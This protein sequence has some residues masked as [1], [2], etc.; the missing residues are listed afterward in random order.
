MS[1]PRWTKEQQEVIDSR[2]GNLLVAAAA[3]SGKTAVLVQRIINMITDTTNP[4]DID[5]LLVVTFTNAAASEMKERVQ[6][7]IETLLEKD[8]TNLQLK[9]QLVLL[10][11][12]NITTIHSFCLNII[13]EYFYK[14]NLTSDFR[15]GS[16]QELTLLKL[17][18]MDEVFEEL[19]K[20]ENEE[21]YTLVDQFGSTRGDSNLRELLLNMYH[22]VVSSPNPKK[23]LQDSAKDFY[24]D[25][26]F[27]FLQTPA[28]KILIETLKIEFEGILQS[29]EQIIEQVNG[30]AE[31][32]QYSTKYLSE[33][34]QFKK[35]FDVFDKN[36]NGIKCALDN[37]VFEDY[38]SGMKRLPKTTE[39]HIKKLQK[40]S[41]KTRDKC[42]D[43]IV[44][45]RTEIFFREEDDIKIEY[46]KLYTIS[47]AISDILSRF[48][49]KY[50]EVKKINNIIDFNDIEHF[51]IKLLTDEVNGDLVPSEIA[52]IYS[53][54]FE[55]IFIDEYQDSNLTQELILTSISR[56][57]E[58]RFMVGDLKQSIYKFRQARPEIF[59]EKYNR[60]STNLK[61]IDKKILLHKNF[62]SRGEVLDATNFIFEHIMRSEVGGLEYGEEEKLNLGG[63]FKN[64]T[65]D[66]VITGGPAELHIISNTKSSSNIES[67]DISDEK[68]ELDK[69]QQEA[70]VIGNIIKDLMTPNNKGEIFKVI[71]KKTGQYRKVNFGDIVILLR[72]TS[73]WQDTIATELGKSGIPVTMSSNS[74]YLNSF[75]IK[76]SMAIMKAISNPYEDIS[77][78]GALRTS[79]FNF[80]EDD[81]TL[82]KNNGGNLCFYELLEKHCEKDNELGMK[83]KITLEKINEFIDFSKKHSIYETLNFIYSST[84][85]YTFISTLPN[86]EI[87]RNNL[88]LLLERA[89]VFSKDNNSSIDRFIKYIED[90]IDNELDLEGHSSITGGNDSVNIM[91]IHKSKGLEFPVVICAGMGKQFN[92][93]DL[94]NPF[95]YHIDLGYGP[96]IIDTKR[97]ITYHSAKKEALKR[98]MHIETLAE[99]IRILYVAL[100]RPKEKLIITGMVND[101]ESSMEKWGSFTHV[102]NKL[103]AYA[104]LKSSTYLD[105]I[106]PTVLKHNDFKD[107]CLEYEIEDVIRTKHNSKWSYKIWDTSELSDFTLEVDDIQSNIKKDINKEFDVILSNLNKENSFNTNYKKTIK[108]FSITDFLEITHSKENVNDNILLPDLIEENS[109]F[110][111]TDIGNIFHETMQ[112]IDIRNINS[113]K[114]VYSEIDRLVK[115][116]LLLDVEADVLNKSR[117]WNFINSDLGKRIKNSKDFK[118]EQ[119]ISIYLDND[120][121]MKQISNIDSAIINGIIDIYFEE[122][123]GLVIIDYKTDYVDDKNINNII[124]EYSI[125]LKLY[126]EA[127]EKI[128]NKKVKECYLHLFSKQ[129]SFKI[130]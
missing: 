88:E 32:K 108:S 82:L 65:E 122:E 13:K 89:N 70:K 105:W 130:I 10:E 66:K 63:S 114:D 56:N 52:S 69:I 72:S 76:T 85:Y 74:G 125:Q 61:E 94:K 45:L 103:P 126:K 33:F 6:F 51:A 77:L 17:K 127:L 113:K 47:K 91:T 62:R 115:N 110:S 24:I 15:I 96:Q 87:R 12:A 53:E 99:E 67:I 112:K 128:T 14:L 106:V 71:D 117:I 16:E 129:E 48:I 121:T 8:A 97:K 37:I 22:F 36:W 20:E 29:M 43:D 30:I 95:L 84:N 49:D 116:G 102:E 4:I 7:A 111:A 59:L 64:N 23:W 93:M 83:C 101:L 55:E 3:G 39:E 5:K 2:K 100:T 73:N 60:Y 34:Y 1:N 118:R 90:L 120:T 68:E 86:G 21:F 78:V 79:C 54:K 57:N 44:N 40:N 119:P 81:L 98:K 107:L 104:I 80:T 27:N 109:M 46:K 58:N 19:Y 18:T 38:R 11:K 9:Q 42:K 50:Q 31:L 35:V 26:T 25:D 28:G 123:D 92:T 124:D 75:E 41:K